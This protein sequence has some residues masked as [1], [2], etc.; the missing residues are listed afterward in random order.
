MRAYVTLFRTI[1]A[2]FGLKFEM[3]SWMQYVALGSP[4]PAAP[5]PP[6]ASGSTMR[7]VGDWLGSW[8]PST[9]PPSEAEPPQTAK[10]TRRAAERVAVERARLG[11]RGAIGALA[12][13][14]P[15]GQRLTVPP[16][17][18]IV[19]YRLVGVTE[20]DELAATL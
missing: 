13:F 9:A 17:H 10:E 14:V 6:A 18:A 1:F 12:A 16:A 5:S 3:P 7:S 15:I 8:L 2:A 4:P 11:P 19:A 20:A